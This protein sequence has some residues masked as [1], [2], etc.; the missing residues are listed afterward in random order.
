MEL[1]TYQR[2]GA[3]W[4]QKKPFRLLADEMGLGKSAQ[5]ITAA[6][7]LNALPVLVLCPAVARSNW[8]REWQKF[9][10][11]TL[12]VAALMTSK[13]AAQPLPD[14]TI[15]SY[16]LASQAAVTSALSRRRWAVCVLDESHYLKNRTA[17][18]TKAC[19]GAIA[20]S[21]ERLWC[22]SGTPAPNNVAELWPVLRVAGA[23]TGDYWSFVRDFCVTHDNGFGIQI[24]GARNVGQ[25]KQ[26]MAPVMLRR[27]KD[28]VMKDLPP[29]MFSDTVVEASM[30]DDR[31][32]FTAFTTY[33][34]YQ[35]ERRMQVFR[36]DMAKQ[37]HLL[38]TLAESGIGLGYGF[39]HDASPEAFK[40]L[41][42]LQ[43]KVKS[44]RKWIGIQKTPKVIEMIRAE[45]EAN[46]YEKIV[47]F[48]VHMS[49]IEMLQFGLKDYGAVSLWGGTPAE[50]R[51]RIIKKFQENPKCRVF[52]GQI[53]AAG[54][55]ITLTAAHNVAVV[56]A[57][58][59]PANNQQ[60]V[61]RCH[62]IGQTKPVSVRFFSLAGSIDERIQ[63]VL[64]RKTKVL[65][66]VFD[67]AETQQQKQINPFS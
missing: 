33:L 28:E 1:F 55:A 52:V 23:Y 2:D 59:T 63:Q 4:L 36:D 35:P 10:S 50:K 43:N 57:D 26:L 25:L 44:Y 62:R 7:A 17:K 15:C 51:G 34:S 19:L 32:L 65:T 24:T 21:C 16:D 31:S 58:W 54:T 61:M 66:D 67:V 12:K 40:I 41:E 29:I 47:V 6:D 11:R 56:E 27:M 30:P 22:L 5:A 49:V 14:V 46:A 64:R 18:R 9:S 39:G 45:L 60:A 20:K 42:G 3:A 53:V 38:K 37:E 13:Q 8:I 48:G